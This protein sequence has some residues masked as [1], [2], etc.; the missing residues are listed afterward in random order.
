MRTALLCLALVACGT[1]SRATTIADTVHGLDT[2][3]AA[4]HAYGPPHELQLAQQATSA[5]AGEKALADWKSLRSKLE[6]GLEAC[7][8]A[9]AVAEDDKKLQAATA[10]AAAFYADLVKAGVIGGGK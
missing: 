6:L 5:P 2:A 3:G 7:Y 8:R 10:Q 4:L 9:L 1:S